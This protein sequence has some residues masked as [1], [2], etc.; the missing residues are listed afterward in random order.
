MALSTGILL[1]GGVDQSEPRAPALLYHPDLSN[2]VTEPW[3]IRSEPPLS[4]TT[5]DGAGFGDIAYFIGATDKA[6]GPV[7]EEYVGQS[8]SWQ[9]SAAPYQGTWTEQQV[10][11]V[12]NFLY[13]IGGLA[14][15]LPTARLLR[16]QAI[17]TVLF[18]SV[19]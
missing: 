16:Y 7:V 14:D 4:G 2:T 18:P 9:M 13:V 19:Q 15:G 12:G 3:S 1:A 6:G 5:L 17:F 11:R 10:T 8:D